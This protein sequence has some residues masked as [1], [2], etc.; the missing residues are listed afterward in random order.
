MFKLFP[1]YGKISSNNPQ[2]L[3]KLCFE[4]SGPSRSF[5]ALP[6]MAETIPEAR[7]CY[8][9]GW[10]YDLQLFPRSLVVSDPEGFD[11]G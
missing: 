7:R 9:M 10:W 5:L 11:C 2:S 4:T 8:R 3:F 6:R 1:Y